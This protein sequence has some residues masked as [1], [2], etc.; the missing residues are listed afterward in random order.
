MRFPLPFRRTAMCLVLGVTAVGA[1]P[2]AASADTRPVAARE[3]VDRLP[4]GAAQ[5]YRDVTIFPREM[6]Y[7][8]IPWLLDL[9]EGI[10]L[11]KQENRPVIIWVSGDDPL[12]RC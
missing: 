9:D 6:K 7:R 3:D 10:R 4:A 1:F 11:A 8:Q 12:E 5:L 2:R